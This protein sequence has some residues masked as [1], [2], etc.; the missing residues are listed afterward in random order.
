[1]PTEQPVFTGVAVA[2]VTFFDEHGH[3]D[4]GATGAHAAHLNAALLTRD[5][6]RYRAYFPEVALV[7]PQ[8]R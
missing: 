5:A 6:R 3:V 8:E 4:V 7:A 1:M 2:L